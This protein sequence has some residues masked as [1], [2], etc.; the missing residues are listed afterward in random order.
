MPQ[1]KRKSTSS[2]RLTAPNSSK[3]ASRFVSCPVC[4][5]TVAAFCIN[6]HLDSAECGS[7]PA[8]DRKSQATNSRSDRM[9]GA[10]QAAAA[11]CFPATPLVSIRQHNSGSPAALPGTPPSAAGPEGTGEGLLGGRPKASS[12]A[13][14]DTQFTSHPAQLTPP[15]QG[16]AASQPRAP[17]Q[18]MPLRQGAAAQQLPATPAASPPQAPTVTAGPSAAAAA[19]ALSEPVS[20]LPAPPRSLATLLSAPPPVALLRRS[21]GRKVALSDAQLMEQVRD[22]SDICCHLISDFE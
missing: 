15:R 11:E 10:A 7:Q 16:A 13:Q 6:E 22:T 2:N 4:S 8:P 5:A 9:I 14:R 21:D 3:A 1:Q 12:E 19:A 17:A 18:L 20:P